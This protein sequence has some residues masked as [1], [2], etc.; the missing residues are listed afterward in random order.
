MTQTATAPHEGSA[1]GVRHATRPPWRGPRS[2]QHP[3]FRRVWLAT[4][5]SFSSRFIEMTVTAWVLV[6]RTDSPLAITLAGFFR[7]LPFLIAGPFVGVI[8]DRY[9]R[10]RIVRI[11]EIATAMSA[12]VVATLAFMDLLQVWHI[13]IFVLAAGTL[14]TTA[15]PA[16]RAYMIGVV[17]KRNM[18]P[19]LALDMIGWTISNIVASNAAGSILRVLEPAWL[20][21]WLVCSSMFSLV[22]LRG[23]PV[24]WKRQAD[25]EREPM[26]QSIAEG[27]KYVGRRRI[28]VAA[29]AV[30]A[31]TN[32]TGFIFELATPVFAK[33]VLHSDSR[34]LGLLI[35]APSFGALVTGTIL[36]VIGTRMNRPALGLIIAGTAQHILTIFWSYATWFPASFGVLV[37]IGLFTFAFGTMNTATFMVATPDN[38][39]GRVQ[40]VQLFVIGTFPVSGLVVGALANVIG[41]QEAVRWMAVGGLAAM[42]LIWVAFPELRRPV[43]T[44]V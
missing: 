2:L 19:A 24:F 17:G 16:R 20:Y 38:M 26:L 18:T 13:Y 21:L 31:V 40:G 22:L 35:S 6:E 12:A 33:D 42:L 7:Y 14:W 34:G 29:V 10:I 1:K 36:I 8:A 44:E 11:S 41:P 39:R 5:L 25:S 15:M 32:F 9:P 43:K 3:A 37:V 30:V 28:L 27:F 23:L 4:L